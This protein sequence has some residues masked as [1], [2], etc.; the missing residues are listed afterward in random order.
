MTGF[1][2]PS[3]T[4]TAAVGSIVGTLLIVLAA[5][6]KVSVSAEVAG[7]ITIIVS[8][9]AAVVTWY[10]SRQQRAGELPSAPDGAIHT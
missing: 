5:F 2:R 9:A 3:E 10:V 1:T 4:L 7:A 6:T 8:W